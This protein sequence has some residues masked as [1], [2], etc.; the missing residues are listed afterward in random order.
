M[1]SLSIPPLALALLLY[2][3]SVLPGSAAD[4]RSASNLPRRPAA[5]NESYSGVDVLYDS[6]VDSKGHNLRVI[7]THPQE[8]K[9]PVPAVFL[10]AWLSCDSVEARP[11]SKSPLAALFTEIA[12]T[13]GLAFVRMDKE[14]QGDSEGDCASTDFDTELGAYREAFRSML[15]YRFVDRSKV[16]ILGLSNGGGIAPLIAGDAPVRGY[17]VEGAWVKTWFEHMM[18]IERR[19]LALSGKSAGEVNALMPLEAMLYARYLIDGEAPADIFKR[20]PETGLWEDNDHQHQ[21]GRPIAYYQQLQKLNL[22]AAWS[23]VHSPVLVLHGQYDWIMSRSDHE[24]IAEIV[25][26][27]A[28]GTARFVELPN[29]GHGFDTYRDMDDAFKGAG[30]PIDP[31]NVHLIVR[32]FVEHF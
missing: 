15:R 20:Y 18:E 10:V 21:Y 5:Q 28:A 12:R 8:A 7:V 16:F 24:A 13:P 4:S 22:A 30:G 6:V 27:N 29:T 1:H 25:N 2:S 17:V 3:A 32:W 11:G 26:A 23:K 9:G 14:G 19:R 31:N